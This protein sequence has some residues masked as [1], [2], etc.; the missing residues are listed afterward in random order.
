MLDNLKQFFS[1]GFDF[2]W[3]AFIRP[4]KSTYAKSNLKPVVGEINGKLYRRKD[5]KI[6]NKRK[7]L[8]ECSLYYPQNLKSFPVVIYLHGLTGNRL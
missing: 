8:M 5:F 2:A 6:K 4:H 3:K 7:I 1:N